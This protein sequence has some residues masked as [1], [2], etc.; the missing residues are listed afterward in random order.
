MLGYGE[1]STNRTAEQITDKHCPVHVLTLVAEP[2]TQ[3]VSLLNMNLTNSQAIEN[4]L[5]G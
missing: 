5:V 1:G 2:E 4:R 3:H